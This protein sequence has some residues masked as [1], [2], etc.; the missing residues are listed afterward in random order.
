M[1]KMRF[2]LEMGEK[3]NLPDMATWP[4]Q[5]LS[6]SVVMVVTNLVH[7]VADVQSIALFLSCGQPA[8]IPADG[9]GDAAYLVIGEHIALAH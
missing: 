3:C 6:A 8:G 5:P 1:S 7:L 4:F 9:M 2:G